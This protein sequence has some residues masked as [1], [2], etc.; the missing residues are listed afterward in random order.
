MTQEEIA[1]TGSVGSDC[2]TNP[3]KYMKDCNEWRNNLPSDK[4]GSINKTVSFTGCYKTEFTYDYDPS[5]ELR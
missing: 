1:A 3:K 2:A 5:G 4:A